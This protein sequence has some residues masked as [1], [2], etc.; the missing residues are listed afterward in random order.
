M[1]F[2]QKVISSNPI[3]VNSDSN[4]ASQAPDAG[5]NGDLV[6]D[7]NVD[8]N[9]K[10]QDVVYTTSNGAPYPHPYETQRAGENGP[11]LLQDFHLI[12]LLSHFDRERIPE[13]VVHANGSGAHGFYRTT[14]SLEDLTTADIFKAGK[15]CPIT[16]RFSTVG[17]ES[18]SHDCAR[19]PRGF[20][21]KFRTDEGNW[22]MVA[23][24]T[25]VFFLRDPAKFPV[26]LA[27]LQL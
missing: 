3:S 12:D 17:G 19:D 9:S 5:K 22:D 20:S 14:D 27:H 6:R 16:I 26:S 4:M 15:S 8:K 18:G 25:P 21:V 1:N 11:L 10:S 7:Y 23:N 13:R 24:N 2:L